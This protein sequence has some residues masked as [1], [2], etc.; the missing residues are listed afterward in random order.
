MQNNSEALSGKIMPFRLLRYFTLVSLISIVLTTLLLGSW[1][2][3]IAVDNLITSEERHNVTLARSMARSLWPQY[4]ALLRSAA[5]MPAA[6]LGQ[7]PE[8]KSIE[9]QLNAHY[10]GVG[11]VKVKLYDLNGLTLFSSDV[12]EIGSVK[13]GQ[14]PFERARAGEVVSQLSFRDHA[15]AHQERI[16]KRNIVSSYVP[17]RPSETG[18]IEAV[19]ELYKDVT[20]LVSDIENTQWNVVLGIAIILTLLFLVLFVVVRYADRVIR[21][22]NRALLDNAAKIEHQAFHDGLTGLPNRVLFMD[23]LEHAIEHAKRD[24]R[25]VGLMFIDLD[26]FKEVNDRLGHAKGDELVCIAAERITGCLRGSDTAARLAGDEFMVILEGLH[27]VERITEV[28][29]RIVHVMAKPIELGDERLSITCSIGIAAYPFDEQDDATQLI[30][31]ADAAMYQ[32]KQRGRNSYAFYIENMTGAQQRQRLSLEHELYRGLENDEFCVYFQPKVDVRNWTMTS[33]E[34]L[35][36]WNH[37]SDGIV[38]P[39]KFISVL[40]ETGMI[41][42]LGETILHQSCLHNRKW[43]DEGL[44][45]L[46]VAVNVSA[47]QFKEYDFVQTVDHILK[48][49]GMDPRHLELE[50]TESCLIDDIETN[51][52]ILNELQQRG[53]GITIDDFGTGYSSLS[54]LCKL[55]VT[56]LKIDRSFVANMNQSKEQ[57]SIIT[58]IISFAHGLKMNIVAEGVETLEELTFLSAMRCNTIQGFL[59]SKPLSVGDFD[60][61]YRS[62]GSFAHVLEEVRQA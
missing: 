45:A 56:T 19:F 6:A 55:P 41:A 31:K 60:R 5:T 34:A 25:L 27:T 39:G 61:L 24:E 43:Q 29:K 12:T 51:V 54:Y 22:Y 44:P 57:R 10:Q 7:Q 2:R 59:F 17:L 4:S 21:R 30:K 26:K 33:M 52:E 32:A 8:I 53:M 35:A 38:L 16:E 9:Q 40:E 50:L 46:K 1:L 58:A 62:G 13:Q 23:R 36:R 47:M 28:A 37:R 11:I 49:T 42:K 20:P 14:A 3:S 18:P 15:Y 48:D